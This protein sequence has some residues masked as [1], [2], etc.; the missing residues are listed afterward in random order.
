MKNNLIPFPTSRPTDSD[1]EA[2]PVSSD[3]LKELRA[4]FDRACADWPLEP[5]ELP[6]NNK[7]YSGS[8]K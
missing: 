4:A 6:E 2:A 5:A 3:E 1:V 8:K 7:I